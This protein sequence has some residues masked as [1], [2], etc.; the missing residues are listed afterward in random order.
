[1]STAEQL[2]AEFPPVSTAEW[3]AA[4]AAD[5]KGASYEEKLIW[6]VPEG[7]A[8]R[9]YYRAED[10]AAFDWANTA[11][12]AFPFARG[13]HAQAGWRIRE[14]IDATQPADANRAAVAAVA[15]GA[16]EIAFRSVSIATTSDVALLLVNLGEIPVHF[17]CAAEKTVRL[18]FEFLS[19]GP[20]RAV[21]SAGFDPLENLNFAEETLAALPANF[22]PFTIDAARAAPADASAV[23]QAGWALAAAVNFLSAM[24]ERTIDPD[25]TAAAIE[26]S[27]HLGA[28]YFFEIARLR[29]FRM[30]WARVVESFGGSRQHAQARIV[31]HTA[32]PQTAIEDSHWNILR[33]AT[34]TMS[35]I[36]GG[37][38]SIS[39]APF[40]EAAE[41]QN[42]AARRLARNTQLLLKQEAFL[43]RVADAGGGS[44]YLETLTGSI[45]DGAWKIMQSI[46][47]RGGYTQSRNEQGGAKG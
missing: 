13:P 1:M 26:F 12:G 10:L 7:L 21:I 16:E 37:A 24:D 11:P 45:A 22:V 9:P 32:Y 42:E 33:A 39:I 20:R 44:Y 8:V 38:D 35:A 2:L 31:A 15:A 40:A 36:L 4:I 23:E 18:L 30:L 41:A 3:E 28:N 47:A 6:Q 14:D 25:R 29:A 43:A 5:L 27:F 34:Q 46:E 19:R 17:A